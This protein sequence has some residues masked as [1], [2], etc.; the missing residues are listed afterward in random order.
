VHT[1]EE[2]GSRAEAPN[3]DEL[4]DIRGD[5]ARHEVAK[6]EDL[7][8]G[9]DLGGRSGEPKCEAEKI[10]GRKARAGEI[11]TVVRKQQTLWDGYVKDLGREGRH[12]L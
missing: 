11:L 6:C 3:A 12:R 10:G 8:V 9:C 4:Q 2:D 7:V 5:K 1:S